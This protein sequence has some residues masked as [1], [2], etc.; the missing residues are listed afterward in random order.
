MDMALFNWARNPSPLTIADGDIEEKP[1]PRI[2][3]L[4]HT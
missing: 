3:S 2:A 4:T 1:V